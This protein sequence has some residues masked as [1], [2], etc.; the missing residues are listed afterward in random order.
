MPRFIIVTLFLFTFGGCASV[1]TA[2]LGDHKAV[3]NDAFLVEVSDVM[4]GEPYGFVSVSTLEPGRTG[5]L[6]ERLAEG[7]LQAMTEAAAAQGAEVLVTER[8]DNRRQKVF[9]A[10]GLKRMNPPGRALAGVEACTHKETSEALIRA[11]AK[12]QR[13]LKGLR[14]ARKDLQGRVRVIILVDG[15]GGVYQ[16][17]VAPDS[18]RDGQ[19]GACGLDA[20]HAVDF[21]AHDDVLCRV[22]LEA[23][24]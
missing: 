11:A 9:Y 7:D 1:Q 22:E 14:G 21:G 16:A 24:L 15:L 10:F 8:I 3:P 5:G 2:T 4:P 17:A 19:M 23:G 6:A 20:A 13:C 18:T 12:A